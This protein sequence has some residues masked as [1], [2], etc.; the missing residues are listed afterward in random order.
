MEFLVLD[1]SPCGSRIQYIQRAARITRKKPF[2][3]RAGKNVFPFFDA[4]AG[5]ACTEGKTHCPGRIHIRLEFTTSFYLAPAG[6]D[7]RALD[8]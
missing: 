3:G 4:Y 1:S 7:K 8:K 6:K 2:A 5:R